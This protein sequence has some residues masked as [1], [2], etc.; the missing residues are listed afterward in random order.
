MTIANLIKIRSQLMI[1]IHFATPFAKINIRKKIVSI[2][3][4][5]IGSIN[6][7]GKGLKLKTKSRILRK[8]LPNKWAKE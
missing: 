8:N 7:T 1:S 4:K 3:K 6:F 5:P 2:I